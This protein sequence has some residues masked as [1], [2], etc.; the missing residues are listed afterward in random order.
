MHA[1][2]FAP[3]LAPE[4]PTVALPEVE[5]DHLVRVLRL[6]VGEPVMVFDGRGHE[7]F[8]RVQSIARHAVIVSIVGPASAAPEPSVRLALAQAVL[9]R[10]RMDDVVRDAA[11]LG[12]S[13]VQPV[14]STRT[15]AAFAQL[16]RAGAVDR[17]SRIAIASVKQCGRAV[18]PVIYQPRGLPDYLRAETADL[19]IILVEPG[20]RSRA[21]GRLDAVRSRPQPS[22][23]AVLIGPE[24]GWTEEEI[25][26]AVAAGFLAITLGP[27]TLRADATPV[28]AISVLQFLWGDL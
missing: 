18:V 26:L 11:M 27:R 17:W 10:D 6:G 4:Q 28:A 2:F 13:A 14:I 9:K 23:A 20:L 1:R 15:E 7:F 5:A 3:D 21:F 8:G 22:T 12:A 16:A 24:G 19:R 25:D